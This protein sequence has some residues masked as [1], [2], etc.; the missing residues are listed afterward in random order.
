MTNIESLV[1]DLGGVL[2]D[3]NPEYLYH[4]LI[5]DEKERKWFLDEICSPEWNEEQDAGRSLAEGTEF[6]V[7]KYPQH[8]AAIRAY[9]GRWQEM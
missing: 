9:Y 3:W 1:F 8:E 4:K 6:L 5:P 2:I 7:R